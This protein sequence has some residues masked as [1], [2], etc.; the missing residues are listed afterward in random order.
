MIL[1]LAGNPNCGKTTLFN[2]LTGA[3]QHVGNWPGVTVEQKRGTLVQRPEVEVIDLPGLYSLNAYTPE[4]EVARD[5]LLHQRPQAVINIVDATV[6][7]R[8]LFL[9]LQLLERGIPVVLALNMMDEVR[10]RGDV[11]DTARLSSELGVPVVSI[12]ARRGEGI[13]KLIDTALHLSPVECKANRQQQMDAAM[14][15]KRIE[16]IMRRAVKQKQR[17]RTISDRIDAVVLHPL[18]AYPVFALVMLLVFWLPFG[19]VGKGLQQLMTSCIEGIQTWLS[20]W[21]VRMSVSAWLQ[22][23]VID[24][25]FAG[26][27][28]LMPFLPV[29]LLLFLCL[30]LLEDSGYMARCAWIMDR[31]LRAM[32][33]AGG[34]FI[35]LLLGFG[36]TV[37]A[38]MATRSMKDQRQRRM[39][40]LLTPL[41]S[42]GAKTPVYTQLAS[43]FFPNNPFRAVVCLYAGGIALAAGIGRFLRGTSVSGESASFVMELPPY[44]LPTA[45]NVLRSMAHRAGDFMKRA[46]SVILLASAVIWFLRSFTFLIQPTT[47]MEGSMLGIVAGWFV[48]IFAPLGFGS[49]AAVTALLCGL[50]AKEN[51]VS[52]LMLLA[53]SAGVSSAFSGQAGAAAY[54]TFVLLYSPCVAALTAIRRELGSWRWALMAA[55]GQTG[56]AWLCSWIVFRLM[57][58]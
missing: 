33:L 53:G 30:S 47:S 2:S 52:T 3:N 42:C 57:G 40:V 22:G 16:E 38:V 23:L 58:G 29:I 48:P 32:G 31:P 13:D 14:R 41:M 7:E 27:G 45:G 26:V 51:I 12:S 28:S 6:L 11:I 54:V 36:C 43:L 55:L 1:A 4:E 35:P 46:F 18:L 49:M 34:S 5:Y 50:M 9:T 24:G 56:L 15:Y 21:L 37:P 10:T 8:S 17:R 19:S 25:I 44:R 20:V 39:T